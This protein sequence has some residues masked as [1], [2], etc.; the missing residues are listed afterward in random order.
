MFRFECTTN[1][2]KN[3]KIT[4]NKKKHLI[5]KLLFNHSFK[6]SKNEI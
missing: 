1:D 3:I 2:E 6:K 5:A 4:N